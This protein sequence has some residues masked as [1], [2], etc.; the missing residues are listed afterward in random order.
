[1]NGHIFLNLPT[2]MKWLKIITIVGDQVGVNGINGAG[3]TNWQAKKVSYTQ[4]LYLCG[5][6]KYFYWVRSLNFISP[7]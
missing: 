3:P 6:K 4:M 7:L 2:C 1:M 5:L